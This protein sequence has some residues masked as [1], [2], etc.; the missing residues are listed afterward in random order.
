MTTRSPS[1]PFGYSRSDRVRDCHRRTPTTT[2]N[3]ALAA[4][5][6]VSVG[7]TVTDGSGHG[8]PLYAKVSVEGPGGVFDYT[9]PTNG[10]YSFKVP[11]SASYTLKVETAAARLPDRQPA[12]HRRHG[13]PDQERRGAGP[14]RRLHHGAGLQVRLRRCVRDL[15]RDGRT[16]RLD[17]R[18]QQE[19]R[20]GLEVR[21]PGQPR[22][23][24]RR[25]GG[26]A[27]IDS[28]KYGSGGAQDTSLVSPVVDLTAVT[29]PV[30]RFNQDFNWLGGEKA[31]VDLS[32]DGGT[33][34]TNVLTQATADA[35][36]VKEIAIPQ[37]AGKS[38]VQVRFHYYVAS[39]DWWW[40]VDNVL[41]GSQINCEPIGGGL[42]VGNVKDANTGGTVNGAVVTRDDKP[43]RD[44]H[45]RRDAGGHRPGRRLLL[46]VLRG[47]RRPRLHRQGRQLRQLA[48]DGRSSRPTGSRRPTSR[49]PPAASRSSPGAIEREPA[50]ARWQG[51]QVV[52]RHQ[53]RW[54]ARST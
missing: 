36:G 3:F 41:I 6:T 31:D 48:A 4:A 20:P 24:D 30:I 11:S 25:A 27:I 53:H 34:W 21:R 43:E 14:D 23:P 22:Q 38:A 12:D 5:P 26:F 1:R 44:R 17:R 13:Q 37:A 54:R 52:H 32:I 15:R 47:R 16:E 19:Q 42:V 35:R 39:Y 7:G 28:D 18:R 40:E 50:A 45:H 33:T 8:W 9:T 2:K 49:S 29:A 51:H 46:A 10:R